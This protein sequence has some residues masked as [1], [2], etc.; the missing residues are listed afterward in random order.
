MVLFLSVVT[1]RGTRWLPSR[2]SNPHICLDPVV[3][4]QQVEGQEQARDGAHGGAV[5]PTEGKE[6]ERG[7]S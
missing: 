3:V 5:H 7:K 4:G 1:W 6:G 2:T